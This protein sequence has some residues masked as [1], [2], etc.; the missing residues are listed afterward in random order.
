MALLSFP[1]SPANGQLYPVTPT[2]GQNQYQWDALNQTWRLVGVATTVTPGIYGDANNVGQFTVDAQGRITSAVNVA[3]NSPNI[4]SAPASSTSAGNQ[5]EVAFG[6]G[7][8]Y[9]HD[10]MQWYRVAGAVF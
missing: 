9:Y 7:Y 6:S 4:V 1:T 2:V 5:G 10:G 8:F 3:I